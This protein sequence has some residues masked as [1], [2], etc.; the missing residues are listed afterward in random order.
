MNTCLASLLVRA[1][2]NI[3]TN[4]D[5]NMYIYIYTNIH[6]MCCH[7]MTLTYYCNTL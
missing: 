1:V 3:N 6:D 2:V 4:I 7:S 5:M